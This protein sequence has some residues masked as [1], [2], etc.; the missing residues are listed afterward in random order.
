MALWPDL[1]EPASGPGG[2]KRVKD[3]VV[4]V[5]TPTLLNNAPNDFIFGVDKL[6]MYE[7]VRVRVT[8]QKIHARTEFLG[9]E[10]NTN[11]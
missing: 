7:F 6:Y 3:R 2:G 5:Y 10:S 1:D 4:R 9:S 8:G 11:W